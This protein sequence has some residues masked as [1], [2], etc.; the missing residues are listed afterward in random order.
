MK[1]FQEKCSKSNRIGEHPCGSIAK[2]RSVAWQV[3]ASDAPDLRSAAVTMQPLLFPPD[4]LCWVHSHQKILT[5]G[6][7]VLNGDRRAIN[8]VAKAID[9]E[10]GLADRESFGVIPTR[11]ID[12]E[13]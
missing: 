5:R 3:A 7:A 13:E 1:V 8:E 2:A 6:K 11:R 12:I 4:D 9:R 10:M